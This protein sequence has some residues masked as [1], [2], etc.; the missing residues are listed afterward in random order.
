MPVAERRRKAARELAQAARRR[1]STLSPVVIEGRTIAQ[2]VLG[3]GLVR[4][5][6][7]LQRLRQPPAAR[8]H[9]RAQ[10]LG[11]RSADRAGRGR[12]AGERLRALPGR[13]SKVDAGRRRRAG[14]R[15]CAGL[16]GRDRLAGRA[17]AGPL[18]A[19]RDGAHL[20][21]GRRAC[22]PRRRRSSFTA[23][24]PTGR[25]CASTSRPCSTASARGS[26]RSP[27][28][29]FTLRK[30]DQKRSDRRGRHRGAFVE[31]RTSD[32]QSADRR[33]PVGAVRVGPGRRRRRRIGNV[34]GAAGELAGEGGE[35]APEEEDSEVEDPAIDGE[36]ALT[37]SCSRA[38]AD[39][40]K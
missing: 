10:R 9:L 33:Q 20:P 19:R 40:G 16:R 17:A 8:A 25:R 32:R 26:T 24:A 4:Q 3:Q 36:E 23:G 28:L 5:P 18:L 22:S 39:P 37:G 21:A 6:R 34:V 27:E 7:A 38:A 13:R 2:H 11:D 1:A 30:V 35:T 14:T 31:A 15:I 12:R 29:L